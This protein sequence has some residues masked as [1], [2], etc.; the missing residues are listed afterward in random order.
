MT[1]GEDTIYWYSITVFTEKFKNHSLLVDL[2]CSDSK[3]M[4]TL[5]KLE[6]RQS[7][8]P[9]KIRIENTLEAEKP[10]V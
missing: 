9:C 5:M 10:M 8:F 2:Y 1:F 6:E 7:Y 3:S 4:S